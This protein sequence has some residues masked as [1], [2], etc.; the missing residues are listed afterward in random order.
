MMRKN[1]IPGFHGCGTHIRNSSLQSSAKSRW[2]ATI[3]PPSAS[4][5]GHLHLLLRVDQIG[6]VDGFAVVLEDRGI[7]Q[8][9]AKIALGDRPQRIAPADGIRSEERRVGKECRSGRSQGE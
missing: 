1:V 2:T 8:A 6:I 5:R 3:T 4:V 7:A 9:A